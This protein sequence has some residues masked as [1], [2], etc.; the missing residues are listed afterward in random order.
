MPKDKAEL[1]NDF[2]KDQFSEASDYDIDIDFSNDHLN[3]IQ[4][5]YCKIYKLLK[6]I[7]AN[8]AAGPDGIHGKVLKNC[9]GS[10]A[11]P[12]SLLFRLSY[13][14][15]HIPAEWKMANIVPG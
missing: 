6:N 4:F 15:G 9:A 8:K 12:L 13:N 7:N 3:D 14:T 1:F 10:L 2:F 11:Y 5:N